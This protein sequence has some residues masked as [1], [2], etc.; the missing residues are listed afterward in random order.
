LFG[1]SS[2]SSD[3]AALRDKTATELS[4]STANT[5]L[6]ILRGAFTDFQAEVV[7]LELEP[8]FAKRPRSFTPNFTARPNAR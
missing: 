8:R 7:A 4:P 2:V 6:K 3:I 5:D 1:E